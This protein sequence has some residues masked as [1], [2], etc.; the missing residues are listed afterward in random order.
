MPGPGTPSART[1]RAPRPTSVGRADVAVE[2]RLRPTGQ[3]TAPD[4]VRV[5]TGN[6]RI[7]KLEPKGER[8]VLVTM[9]AEHLSQYPV[10]AWADRQSPVWGRV[11]DAHDRQLLVRYTVE[12]H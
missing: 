8:N 10:L 5:E 1:A 3:D 11:Q 4:H 6:A 9:D 12:I 2:F 7:T